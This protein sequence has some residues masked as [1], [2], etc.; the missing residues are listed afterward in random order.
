[1]ASIAPRSLIELELIHRLASLFWRLRRAS[2][3]Q[4]LKGPEIIG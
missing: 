4:E 1:M 2:A 3:T